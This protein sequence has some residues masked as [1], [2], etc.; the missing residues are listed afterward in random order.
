MPKKENDNENE[1]ELPSYQKT[2]L[3]TFKYV[4]LPGLIAYLSSKDQ[5]ITLFTSFS[6]FILVSG[7]MLTDEFLNLIKKFLAWWNQSAS[8]VQVVAF[9]ASDRIA[10]LF[11]ELYDKQKGG[12]KY[13]LKMMQHRGG[14]LP[15][16]LRIDPSGCFKD[17]FMLNEK[18]I[19][20]ECTGDG[21]SG[22]IHIAF[23]HPDMYIDFLKIL[24][25]PYKDPPIHEE[26]IKVF[27]GTDSDCQL[28]QKRPLA[29]LF[30]SERVAAQLSAFVDDIKNP[31]KNIHFYQKGIKLPNTLFL[32]GPPGTG[33]SSIGIAIASE[34]NFDYVRLKFTRKSINKLYGGWF[35]KS[36]IVFEDF[37]LS[38]DYKYLL[39]KDIRAQQKETVSF[40]SS[41]T[42]VR[43]SK[44][45]GKD[46][47]K[48]KD[49][50]DSFDNESQTIMQDLM[51]YLDNPVRD[52][53]LIFTSNDYSDLDQSIFR[54][55]RMKLIHVLEMDLYQFKNMLTAFDFE[56]PEQSLLE[57][58][59]QIDTEY[60]MKM[61][62]SYLISNLI[63]PHYHRRHQFASV[64]QEWLTFTT[65]KD[66]R[67]CFVETAVSSFP[68]SSSTSSTTI[69]TSSSSSLSSTSILEVED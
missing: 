19:Y 68:S 11:F 32:S 66:N 15:Y 60:G 37:N 56:I 13:L 5:N 3:K 9:S 22:Y 69:S 64:L 24:K 17:F 48:D 62:T 65:Q 34:L 38:E 33:K 23:P 59:L 16:S 63:I 61:T 36:V 53:V 51:T 4:F 14:N 44:S 67:Q 1:V 39:K 8:E 26:Q 20:F 55:G 2:L 18:K 43:K 6:S 21:D 58:C 47:D 25:L 45:K 28:E 54:P 57:K 31:Q 29:S 49:S 40:F 27:D 50:D 10:N 52:Q 46:E 7:S 30:L 12:S 41:M 35:K 42:R